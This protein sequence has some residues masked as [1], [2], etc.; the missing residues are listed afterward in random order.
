MKHLKKF[1]NFDNSE[2]VEEGFFGPNIKNFITK[3]DNLDT[4]NSDAIKST[5]VEI[6]TEANRKSDVGVNYFKKIKA[7]IDK[8][9]IEDMVKV[10]NEL[11][12][13]YNNN[14]QIGYVVNIGTEL[15]YKA[16]GKI[17]TSSGFAGGGTGGKMGFGGV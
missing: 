11:K 16:A 9:K 4:K 6:F 10:L 1:E 7:N 8:F 5:F 12:E 3:I 2:L 17:K 13:D 15:N 14:K